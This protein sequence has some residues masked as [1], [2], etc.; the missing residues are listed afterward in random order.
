[1]E[2]ILWLYVGLLVGFIAG[3]FV[4]AMWIDRRPS[5]PDWFVQFEKDCV[6]TRKQAP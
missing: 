1:M 2:E 6:F 5:K 3:S 4:T